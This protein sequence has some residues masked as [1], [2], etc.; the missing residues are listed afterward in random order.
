MKEPK[1][2]AEELVYF[3]ISLIPTSIKY[4][5]CNQVHR[6]HKG[7]RLRQAKEGALFCVDEIFKS[8]SSDEAMPMI[9]LETGMYWT[10]VKKEIEKL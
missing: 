9:N 10:N 1:A 5:D 2:K 4:P 6:A 3:F 8:H 7:A